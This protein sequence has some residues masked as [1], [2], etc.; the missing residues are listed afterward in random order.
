MRV[1]CNVERFDVL[2]RFVYPALKESDIVRIFL[3]LVL[4]ISLPVAKVAGGE[5]TTFYASSRFNIIIPFMGSDVGP[6][7]FKKAKLFYTDDNGKTWHFA[8]ET[9]RLE[10]AQTKGMVKGHFTWTAPNE[11]LYG[12]DTV[13]VDGVGN[14]ELGPR[15]I[16]HFVM[17]DTKGPK[18]TIVS[19]IKDSKIGRRGKALIVW[20]YQ[21]ASPPMDFILEY[22]SGSAGK[23]TKI[24]VLD[25]EQRRF[26]W[27]PAP[28]APGACSIRVWGRDQAGNTASVSTTFELT[29]AG[30]VA[31]TIAP[32]E[33][34]GNV[35]SMN[36]GALK[37]QPPIAATLPATRPVAATQPT[38]TGDYLVRFGA[39]PLSTRQSFDIEYGAQS[40]GL[41]GLADVCL[42]YTTDDG[43]TWIRYGRDGDGRSPIRFCSPGDGKYGFFIQ[44]ISGSGVVGSAPKQGDK[45]AF[46]TRVDTQFPALMLNYP[47]G[48]EHLKPSQAIDIQWTAKDKNF[49][50]APIVIRASFD[51]GKT[52]QA[53]GKPLAAEGRMKWNVPDTASAA[54]RLRLEATDQAGNRTIVETAS[55]II[56]DNVSPVVRIRSLKTAVY[57]KEIHHAPVAEAQGV[58]EETPDAK[59]LLKAAESFMHQKRYAEALRAYEMALGVLKDE[60][61]GR[62]QFSFV[63]LSLGQTN[64][65]LNILNEARAI[66]PMNAEVDYMSAVAYVQKKDWFLAQQY[67]LRSLQVAPKSA[68]SWLLLAK[69]YH[70]RTNDEE[71]IKC[72]KRVLKLSK[73]E[74]E[75]KLAEDFLKYLKKDKEG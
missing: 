67:G 5:V 6:S 28:I 62:I 74:K 45:P 41:S 8:G 61:E 14:E 56:V 47:R 12:F 2:K 54:I 49:G 15:T 1:K 19:P 4:V 9:S 70:M 40:Q 21:D 11:G 64:Q 35:P 65:A 75:I 42:Y 16:G 26:N 23:W 25:G 34:M 18:I 3:A 38:S 57:Q 27:N 60:V 55:D 7:G 29:E 46:T 53:L 69:A 59:S 13:A 68:K 63:L 22:R 66:A 52:W 31:R 58:R 51:R 32:T 72:C 39:P 30:I 17:V 24:T 44:G 37:G 73:K 33:V 50:A 10:G 43:A 20:N 71:A 36:G 48:G